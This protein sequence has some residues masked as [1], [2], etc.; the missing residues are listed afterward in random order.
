MREKS[1][2]DRVQIRDPR[3]RRRVLTLLRE[4]LSEAPEGEREL[5]LAHLKRVVS[6]PEA[7]LPEPEEIASAFVRRS[8]GG[9]EMVIEP[10]NFLSHSP[11]G[12]LAII[13][14]ELDEIVRIVREGESIH[15]LEFVPFSE[16]GLKVKCAICSREISEGY[17]VYSGEEFTYDEV[18]PYIALLWAELDMDSE[19]S[20]IFVCSEC[21]H[22]CCSSCNKEKTCHEMPLELSCRYPERW[23]EKAI[24]LHNRHH[25]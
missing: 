13:K 7:G 6:R 24:A 23:V 10:K 1:L 8:K 20:S 19:D 17:Y 25:R 22:E 5:V 11:L 3:L 14:H 2:E 4:A 18:S 15:E 16:E 9:F 21:M 12:Q